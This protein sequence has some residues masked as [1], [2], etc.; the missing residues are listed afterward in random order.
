MIASLDRPRSPIAVLRRE[1]KELL[2]QLAPELPTRTRTCAAQLIPYFTRWQEWKAASYPSEWIYQPL[3]HIREDLMKVFSIHVIR[4]AISLLQKLGYLSIRK[5]S[6]DLNWRNGQDKTHQYLL[7]VDRIKAAQ[8]KLVSRFMA[9]T[10]EK[11]PFVNS[12]TSGVNSEISRFTVDTHTQIPSLI[13]A[14]DSCSLLKEQEKTDF[15][16]ELEDFWEVEDEVEPDSIASCNGTTEILQKEEDFSED[17]FSA[18]SASKCDE[19]M[20]SDVNKIKRLPKLKSDSEALLR[21][22]DRTSG[23]RSQEEREGFYQSLLELGKSQGKKSPVAWASVIVRNVNAGE[24][25]QYLNEY[26]DGLL[27]G[28]CEQ[29]EW[30]VAPGQPFEQ[31][32]SYLKTRNKKTGMTDEEAIAS[33]YQQLKDV[34]LAR[35][36]WESFKRSIVRYGEEW[37]KQKR[38]GVSNAYLP[39]ELLPH[40]EV[41]LEEAASAIASLQTGCVQ[42]QGLAES[43][44]LN[45]ATV[46]L[47]PAKELPSES[48]IAEP[49]PIAAVDDLEPVKELPSE[50]AITEPE[51]VAAVD[52]L[53]PVKELP[54]EPAIAE[55]EPIAAV[56][57][58]EPVK[59]LPSEPAITEPAI[60][61]PEPVAVVDDLDPVKELPSESAIAEPEPVVAA[62][63]TDL[64]PAKELPSEPKPVS[65]IE[66]QEKLNSPFALFESLARTMA[67]ALGYRI[68]EGLVLPAGEEIP[69]LEHLRSLLTNAETRA[70]TAKKIQRLIEGNPQWGFYF[71]EFG[72]LW[73]F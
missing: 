2:D 26:R 64:E 1:D 7:H 19:V 55:P 59:E 22:A 18:V 32:V 10:L 44:K 42:L 69:S 38:L 71:D 27:V 11:S 34:N 15:V 14:S 47:E 35:T 61:E 45:S 21:S 50:P 52:D 20:Q 68:E 66:L 9:E 17:Q 60:A 37:E 6:R 72:E 40:R 58:L 54:S 29:Q 43:A 46:E 49:E 25:C 48:A 3:T 62:D 13:P 28:S 70:V 65:A 63:A 23:F 5:N 16:Q 4:D 33:S 24:P 73:G 36:Q 56:D 12:E 30:E 53:E 41:S 39:P 67:K 31:F 51:P 57:D 8:K